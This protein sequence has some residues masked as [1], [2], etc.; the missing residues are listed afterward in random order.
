MDDDD[1][2]IDFKSL[3]SMVPYSRMHIYRME[4]E[5]KFPLRVQLG[6]NRVAW[7]LSEVRN[8]I[9]SRPVGSSP[10]PTEDA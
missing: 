4:K 7:R 9:R 6:P 10:R 3:E 8:W 2:L 5:G 1:V